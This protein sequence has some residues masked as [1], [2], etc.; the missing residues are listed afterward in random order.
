MTKT[1]SVNG[2][3][4][5]RTES[6]QVVEGN[7]VSRSY[8]MYY[9]KVTLLILPILCSTCAPAFSA[10]GTY[11]SLN[12]LITRSPPSPPSDIKQEYFKPSAK[13]TTTHCPW[14]VSVGWSCS[15]QLRA[16]VR[17]ELTVRDCREMLRTTTSISMEK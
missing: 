11:L 6:P 3:E 12:K 15:R 14:K 1:A 13:G 16:D 7:Q 9:S 17:A 5:A 4:I 8:C 2:V 10:R